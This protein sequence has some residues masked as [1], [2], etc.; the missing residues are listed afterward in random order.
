MRLR[1][2]TAKIRNGDFATNWLIAFTSGVGALSAIVALLP[3]VRFD[4]L[5]SAFVLF[6]CA[7]LAAVYAYVRSQPMHLPVEEVAPAGLSAGQHMEAVTGCNRSLVAQAH[8]LAERAYGSVTPIPRERYEQWLMVNCNIL[9]CLL[10]RS[11]RVVGYF[12]VLPLRDDF[13]EFLICGDVDELKIRREHVLN[14]EAAKGCKYLY[15]AGFAVLDPKT[16]AGGRRASYLLWA[17]KRYLECFYQPLSSKQ[18]LAVAATVE[19]EKILQRYNFQFAECA[20]V[21]SD[22]F[23]IYAAPLTARL[24]NA[25]AAPDWSAACRLSWEAASSG[26]SSAA[27]DAVAN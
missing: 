9:V 18:L 17:L 14:P 8:A 25:L 23:A 4:I 13:A 22:G 21:R 2:V 20:D 15:L 27:D 12:D 5:R 6:G 3:A 1:R 26:G 19:G 16:A 7:T 11:R 10:D 24:L